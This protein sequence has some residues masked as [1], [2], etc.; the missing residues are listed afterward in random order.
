MVPL[1]ALSVVGPIFFGFCD[2]TK[3]EGQ[4]VEWRRAEATELK[5]QGKW[6]S[7]TA[8]KYL[9]ASDDSD[10]FDVALRNRGEIAPL[11]CWTWLRVINRLIDTQYLYEIIE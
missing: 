9:I 3:I 5:I 7:K 4:L 6:F 10:R 1:G 11:D 8:N 2:M